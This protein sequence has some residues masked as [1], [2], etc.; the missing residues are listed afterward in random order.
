VSFHLPTSPDAESALLVS[1]IQGIK[2]G[3]QAA[4]AELVRHY[5]PEVRRFIRFRL[6]DPRLRRL[7]DSVDVCQ[8]VMVRFF[9]GIQ[10]ERL[11]V[12]HPLQL[13]KLLTTM[14][15]NSL[16]DHARK[17]KVRR[18]ISG[19]GLEA[20]WLANVSDRSA[21]PCDRL[22]EA[23]LVDLIRSRMR[24]DEQQALD[25][26]LLGQGWE[27]MSRNLDCEPDALRKRLTRAIDRA[28]K[29]LGLLEDEN[30]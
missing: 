22:E 11:S 3:N 27:E 1:W 14:A 20:D 2:A 19:G 21:S 16:L 28:T 4:A 24:S 23:D 29:E 30:V 9:Q 7:I 18:Q 12:E 25:Q 15:R 17:V 5:E 10:T 26:W 6:T 13:L 8:S